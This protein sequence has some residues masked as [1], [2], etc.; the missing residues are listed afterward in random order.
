MTIMRAIYSDP[1]AKR[2]V[3]RET[4]VAIGVQLQQS[5][6]RFLG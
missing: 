5:Y 1:C 6:H 4:F 2:S 3:G